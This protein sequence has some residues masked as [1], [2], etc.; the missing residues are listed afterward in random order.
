MLVFL[1][2]KERLIHE[3]NNNQTIWMYHLKMTTRGHSEASG[4]LDPVASMVLEDVSF[5]EINSI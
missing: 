4:V 1:K 3:L 2:I 5:T